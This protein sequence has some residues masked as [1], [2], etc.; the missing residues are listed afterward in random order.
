MRVIKLPG[1]VDSLDPLSHFVSDVA[2]DGGLPSEARN[3]L[4]LA[5]E[6]VFT[7]IVLHGY[8]GWDD[9]RDEGAVTVEGGPRQAGAW[10]RFRDQAAPFDPTQVPEPSDLAQPLAERSIGGL[11]VYLVRLTM[12]EFRYQRVDGQNV[13]TI[14][15]A[16]GGADRTP[17]QR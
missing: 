2:A 3:R 5:A 8:Q 10:L 14:A 17:D 13:L 1:V 16:R 12:D 15:L 7:N 9:A 11:G 6:E 4:R